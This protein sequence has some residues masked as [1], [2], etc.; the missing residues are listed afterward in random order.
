V[1]TGGNRPTTER[2]ASAEINYDA[3]FGTIFLNL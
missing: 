3:G 1:D 2:E